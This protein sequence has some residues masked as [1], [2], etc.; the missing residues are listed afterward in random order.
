MKTLTKV[1]LPGDLSFLILCGRAASAKA[2][3]LPGAVRATGFRIAA[4]MAG[5]GSGRS[6]G[7]TVETS[8]FD[9]NAAGQLTWSERL[10]SIL[11]LG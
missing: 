2:N 3:S 8:V 1:F 5:G 6:E 9:W 4:A 10:P 11:S 7:E